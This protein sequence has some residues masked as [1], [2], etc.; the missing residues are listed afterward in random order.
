MSHYDTLK[1]IGDGM[2]V[3]AIVIGLWLALDR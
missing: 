3:M 1:L 2:L